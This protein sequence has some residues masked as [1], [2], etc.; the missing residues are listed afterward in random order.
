MRTTYGVVALVVVLAAGCVKARD[1][2]LRDT[3]RTRYLGI[4]LDTRKLGAAE[5]ATLEKDDP[6]VA[7]YVAKNGQP[8]FLL[9]TTQNDTELIYYLPS[10]VVQFHRPSPGAPSVSG[11]LTPLPN[12]LLAVL[13]MDIQAGTPASG[14][15]YGAD[16]WKVSVAGKS[17]KTCCA[18]SMACVGSCTAGVMQ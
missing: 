16:C 11:Q 4:V 10:V 13:P 15:D 3:P 14:P 17:C 5:L 8:D 9:M 7:A 2:G 1:T 12:A 18:G 6:A